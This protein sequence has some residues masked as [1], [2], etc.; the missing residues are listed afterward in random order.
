M[1]KRRVILLSIWLGFALQ[2]SCGPVTTAGHAVI[3]CV[4]ADQAQI[5]AALL[6]LEASPSWDAI[7]ATA[8]ALGETIGGCALVA[9]IDQRLSKRTEHV[10]GG[11]SGR[12]TLERVRASF[13]GVTW[14]TATGPR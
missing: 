2:G 9:L 5:G 10:V 13:G 3:D 12:A 6:K 11:T 7:E 1:L 4:K 14:Q 8:I